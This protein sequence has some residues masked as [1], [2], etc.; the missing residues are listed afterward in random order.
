MYKPRSS[1]AAGQALQKLGAFRRLPDV[2]A[3]LG[4]D[5]DD[6]LRDAGLTRTELLS[7][8]GSTRAARVNHLLNVCAERTHCP[9]FALLIAKAGGLEALDDIGRLVASSADVATALRNFV[10]YFKYHNGAALVWLETSAESA[11]L[12]YCVY[13]AREESSSQLYAGAAVFACNIL[14]DL[15]G[16]EWSALQV[17]LPFRRPVDVRP[18]REILRAPLVFDANAVTVRFG[19]HWLD[20]PL[21]SADSAAHRELE[22]RFKYLDA[23]GD[24]DFP[25]V[26]RRLVR[27]QLLVD[28]CDAN[29]VA[30]ALAM[31]RRT[32]DRRLEAEGTTFREL[33]DAVMY[34]VARQ[35]LR[36]TTLSVQQVAAHLRYESGA[37][38]STAFRR[39]SGESPRQYRDRNRQPPS[40]IV[41]ATRTAPRSRNTTPVSTG[42]AMV[43]R[44]KR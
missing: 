13:E 10:T 7:P 4:V 24:S 17:H 11:A 30:T 37:N 18:Y 34:D 8:G 41:A 38:F 12:H 44:A 22:A 31:H 33:R 20:K 39:W 32:F 6:V 16:P 36:E 28:K 42:R 5:A 21:R 35:I 19:R 40:A 15:C 26:V 14:R 25:S 9:H 3:Q 1:A 23:L 29:D 2:L 27:R 43:S